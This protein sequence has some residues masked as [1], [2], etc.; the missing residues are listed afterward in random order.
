[1]EKEVGSIQGLRGLL[2]FVIA[3]IF[4]YELLFSAMPV[5]VEPFRTILEVLGRITFYASDIFFILSGYLTH[6]AYEKRM[7]AH[8]ISGKDY[9]LSKIRRIYP[10]VVITAIVNFILEQ[11]G[12]W[13]LGWYPLH[14]EGGALRYSFPALFLNM[15]GLQSGWISEGD[16]LAV[17]G[18]SWFISVLFL[19]YLIHFMQV[20]WVR[21]EKI[22]IY[23][24]WGML[25]LGIVLL[26][27]PLNLPLLFKVDGRGYVGFF[28]GILMHQYLEK[29]EEAK[30]SRGTVP[31]ACVLW[32]AVAL[33]AFGV[34]DCMLPEVLVIFPITVYLAIYGKRSKRILSSGILR[35]LGRIS[36]PLFLC[37]IPTNTLMALVNRLFHWNL[38]Y[39]ATGVWLAH[40]GVSLTVAWGCDVVLT[41]NRKKKLFIT[42]IAGQEE[43]GT[44]RS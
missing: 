18:P 14:G 39:S 4:H 13:R 16:T 41:G 21:K 25:I 31:A 9:L 24:Y 1:M 26:L 32:V 43:I 22:R 17:N 7:E 23:I 8:Q 2:A 38:D 30:R 15:A 34:I 3:Y 37:N 10:C 29:V 19:C 11:L 5:H 42:G 27:Y 28:A 40:I 6:Q 20:R 12:L 35:A 36:L 33:C 44:N